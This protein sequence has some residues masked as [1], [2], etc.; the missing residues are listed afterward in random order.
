[1]SYGRIWV[2]TTQDLYGRSI[3]HLQA[4]GFQAVKEADGAFV[5][6]LAGE[7]DMPC[8]YRC[9]RWRCPERSERGFV[10]AL[11][12]DRGWTVPGGSALRMPPA[13]TL[14]PSVDAEE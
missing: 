8:P 2:L 9:L 7:A 14:D 5:R 4:A 11:A 13:L 12:L 6:L 10:M 1:M 3:S